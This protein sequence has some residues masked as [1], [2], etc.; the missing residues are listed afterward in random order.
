M[1]YARGM[2]LDTDEMSAAQ[3]GREA[4]SKGDFPSV[5]VTAQDGLR[6]HVRD[7]RARGA[8]ALPVVCLPGLARTAEDFAD[9]ATALASNRSRP[10]RVLAIDYRGRGLSHYDR[11]PRKYSLPVELSDLAAVLTA[12]E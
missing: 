3:A 6:L 2:D 10:R 7:Y 12:L 11:D 4:A 8:T 5:F 9:L 1:M